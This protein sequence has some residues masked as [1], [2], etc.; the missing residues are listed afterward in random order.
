MKQCYVVSFKGFV[1]VLYS[2]VLR[3]Y[4]TCSAFYVC[5]LNTDIAAT[6]YSRA[7]AS[8]GVV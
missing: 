2:S 4:C 7:K 1:R 5:V 3:R 6:Q 8:P